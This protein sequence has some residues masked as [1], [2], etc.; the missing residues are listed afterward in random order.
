MSDRV[1]YVHGD[2][3]GRDHQYFPTILRSELAA[4]LAIDPLIAITDTVEQQRHIDSF[5][6]FGVD[7]AMMQ[8]IAWRVREWTIEAGT[9]SYAGT[10]NPIEPGESWSVSGSLPAFL[11]RAERVGMG[12]V[13]RERDLLGPWTDAPLTGDGGIAPS[14]RKW[15]TLRNEGISGA[16]LEAGMTVT[17]AFSNAPGGALDSGEFSILAHNDLIIF[18]PGTNLFYPKFFIEAFFAT[19]VNPSPTV[20]FRTVPTTAHAPAL[21]SPPFGVGEDVQQG[22][23][24][25]INP[26]GGANVIVKLGMFGRPNTQI[27]TPGWDDGGT[28]SITLT[29]RA[30]KFWQYANSEGLPVYNET[31]GAQIRNP[32]S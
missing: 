23:L 1:A 11:L 21:P 10:K 5:W 19:N 26:S 22:T 14:N 31:T 8:Q 29:M 17:Y 24:T 15:K 6:P 32:F 20:L 28:G 18:D 4:L 2:T 9:F 13:N 16:A 3:A 12:N 7:L 27:G 25:I 30:T